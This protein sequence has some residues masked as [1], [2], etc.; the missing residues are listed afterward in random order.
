[1]N[2]A[3]RT[4]GR[5][6]AA[7]ASAAALWALTQPFDKWLFAS[8]YDDV[9]LLG[10]LL[11]RDRAWPA[12]GLALHVG[13]GAMFGAAYAL[14]RERLPG[15]PWSRGLVAAQLENFGLWPLVR[16]TDRYH[17]ARGE[18][19]QLTGNRRALA[20]ATWRHVL[21]GIALGT[22]EDRLATTRA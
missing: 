21:F 17:P 13:N 10:K 1:V 2:S 22:L 12:V 11:T 15:P 20:Q 14:A 16:L 9:E 18:L 4:I 6:A 7:G 19:T 8:G 5:G 3:S